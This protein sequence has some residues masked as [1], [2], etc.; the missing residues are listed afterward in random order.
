MGFSVFPSTDFNENKSTIVRHTAN[1]TQN[2]SIISGTN[3]AY[4]ILFGGGGGSGAIGN[5]A[6]GLTPVAN[7]ITIGAGSNSTGGSSIYG[8]IMTGSSDRYSN[9]LN[10]TVRHP[11]NNVSDGRFA[12]DGLNTNPGAAGS[13]SGAGIILY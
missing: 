7:S 3:M 9:T 12:A 6:I 1:S 4:A 13:G 10:A 8:A 5:I 2:L 11:R